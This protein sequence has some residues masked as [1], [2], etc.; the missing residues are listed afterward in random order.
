MERENGKKRKRNIR[1]DFL[2]QL[3]EIEEANKQKIKKKNRIK[4]N[5]IG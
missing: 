1:M 4:R 5:C 2:L 3:I